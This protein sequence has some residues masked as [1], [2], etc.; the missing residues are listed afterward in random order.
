MMLP[1][2]FITALFVQLHE[3]RDRKMVFEQMQV[4]L[5][6]DQVSIKLQ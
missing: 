1:Y 5:T 6:L 2:I 4:K 3:Y